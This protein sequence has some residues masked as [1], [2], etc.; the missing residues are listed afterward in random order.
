[1]KKR[2]Y[3]KNWVVKVLETLLALSIMFVMLTIESE[4]TLTYFV[5]V[6][7]AFVIA[8]TS[9]TLLLKYA[10]SWQEEE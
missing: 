3:L 4:W 6:I 5:C 9:E 7:V 10:K 2:V 1:M 8:F